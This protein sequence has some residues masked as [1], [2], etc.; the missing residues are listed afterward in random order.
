MELKFVDSNGKIHCKYTVS[1]LPYN[2]H[3]LCRLQIVRDSY[4][5]QMHT[6]M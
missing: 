5:S 4:Q 2:V 3:N 6:N 1:I